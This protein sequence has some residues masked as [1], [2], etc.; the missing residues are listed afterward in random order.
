MGGNQKSRQGA[1]LQ[2]LCRAAGRA[3]QIDD[4]GV[5]DP[6]RPV[7]TRRA[8]SDRLRL[9]LRRRRRRRRQHAFDFAGADERGGGQDRDYTNRRRGV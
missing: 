4:A 5:A 6:Q 9:R 2:H 7:L 8:C 1:Q 3:R